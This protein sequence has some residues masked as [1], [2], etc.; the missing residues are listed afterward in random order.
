ML[1]EIIY[2]ESTDADI[3]GMARLR[4]EHWGAEDYWQKRIKAYLSGELHPQQALAPRIA[5][6]AVAHNSTADDTTADDTIVGFIAGHLTRRFGCDG[7]L[8]WIN[9]RPDYRGQG[10]SSRLLQLL[11]TW[12]KGQNALSVCV[13]CAAD[14]TVAQNFY[15]RHGAADLSEHWLIWKDVSVLTIL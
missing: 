5:Y 1:M 3:P 6:V 7:E 11:A 12:F 10:V 9:V 13:N 15:K 14:N 4:E 8:E 2:K